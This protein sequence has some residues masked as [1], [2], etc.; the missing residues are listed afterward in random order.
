[1]Q[2]D[3]LYPVISGLHAEQI[4]SISQNCILWH[5][6]S[7]LEWNSFNAYGA[8]AVVRDES[9]LVYVFIIGVNGVWVHR[10]DQLLFLVGFH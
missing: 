6:S 10:H 7:C 2:L 3:E 5:T 8:S 9:Y 1:M 4:N